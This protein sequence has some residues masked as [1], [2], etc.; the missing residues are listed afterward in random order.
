MTIGI[1][2]PTPL[3][4]IDTDPPT[5]RKRKKPV[6]SPMAD[7]EAQTHGHITHDGS[8]LAVF[9]LDEAEIAVGTAEAFTEN[10]PQHRTT[11]SEL[12]PGTRMPVAMPPGEFIRVERL[13][14][15]GF[16]LFVGVQVNVNDVG[17]PDP[18]ARVPP[19]VVRREVRERRHPCHIGRRVDVYP[20]PSA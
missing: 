17:G 19:G 10:A 9:Q 4:H 13:Q 5:R 15:I 14:R 8:G 12:P 3:L 7:V 20:L 11:E 6:V 16:P 1:M 2:A 18:A